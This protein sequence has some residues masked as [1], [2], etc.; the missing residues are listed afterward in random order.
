MQLPDPVYEKNGIKVYPRGDGPV[1]HT[2]FGRLIRGVETIHLMQGTAE[3]K[4]R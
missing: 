3:F 1:S 4:K 2:I